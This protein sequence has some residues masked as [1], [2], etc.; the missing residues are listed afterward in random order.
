MALPRT[1]VHGGIFFIAA[2]LR[3]LPDS[4]AICRAK[5]LIPFGISR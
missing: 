4:A 1:C 2:A 5:L 3:I